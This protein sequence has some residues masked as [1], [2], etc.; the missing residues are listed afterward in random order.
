MHRKFFGT[1]KGKDSSSKQPRLDDKLVQE[2]HQEQEK[3]RVELQKQAES[4]KLQDVERLAAVQLE[5]ELQDSDSMSDEL[6]LD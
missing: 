3:K 6:N 5:R 2:Y 1:R 4:E